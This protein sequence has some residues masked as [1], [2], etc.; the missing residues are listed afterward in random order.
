MLIIIFVL[1]F[2]VATQQNNLNN[3]CQQSLHLNTTITDGVRPRT[4]VQ[5]NRRNTTGTLLFGDVTNLS[6]IK[7]L[8]SF[9]F[10]FVDLVHLIINHLKVLLYLLRNEYL[11]G[12]D[13]RIA[14]NW[15]W[16][17]P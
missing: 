16:C 3:R 11:I 2:V 5:I 13:V 4:N 14:C 10:F 12:L 9:Q 15:L 6:S 1:L 7:F 8:H 17:I